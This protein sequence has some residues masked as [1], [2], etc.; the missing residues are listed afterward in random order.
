MAREPAAHD[1]F[2]KQL[3]SEPATVERFLAEQLPAEVVAAMV[4]GSL[5]RR[6]GAF[7]DDDLRHSLSDLLYGLRL[8]GA[9]GLQRPAFA[10]LLLEHKSAPDPLTP[11]QGVG[12]SNPL[13]Q[14]N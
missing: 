13:A 12:G 1:A 7:V 9:D 2:F 6:D 11:L 5:E 14:T 8:Q 4:P 10:V 3:M